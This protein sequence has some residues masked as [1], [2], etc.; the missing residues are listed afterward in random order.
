L[1]ALLLVVFCATQLAGAFFIVRPKHYEPSRVKLA[2]YS[3]LAFTAVQPFVYGT[4]A[5]A[6][7]MSRALTLSGGLLLLVWGEKEKI[8]KRNDLMSMSVHELDDASSDRLQLAGRLLLTFLFLFQAVHSEHGGLHTVLS[9]PSAFN[10]LVSSTL[11]LLSLMTCVGFHTE[12][13]SIGLT[14]VLGLSNFAFYPFWSAP[15][16]LADFYRYY[17]FQTLSVMG[18]LLLL[19]LHGPGGLS[20]DGKQK[21]AI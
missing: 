5:D 18:G 3:L 12:W 20:L 13:S 19:T 14:A 1:A 7:F 10:V 11:I 8:C 2:S 4:H 9:A 16:H 15:A 6:D 21:K 17:F